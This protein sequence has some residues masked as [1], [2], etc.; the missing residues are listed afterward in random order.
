MLL[1]DNNQEKTF[2]VRSGSKCTFL[3]LIRSWYIS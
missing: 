2:I 1:I 3:A